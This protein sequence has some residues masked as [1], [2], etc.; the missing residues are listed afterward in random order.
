MRPVDWDLAIHGDD[1]GLH[2]DGIL[3]D[4]LVVLVV[5]NDEQD[6]VER[7][8]GAR[9]AAGGVR[10]GLATLETDL[11]GGPGEQGGAL[12]AAGVVPEHK[13]VAE[14]AAGVVFKLE[15][16]E[17]EVVLA[18]R[19]IFDNGLGAHDGHDVDVGEFDPVNEQGEFAG[20]IDGPVANERRAGRELDAEVNGRGR[21]S[22]RRSERARPC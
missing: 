7:A 19:A 6:G 13:A 14:R 16:F 3:G 21:R 15:V 2:Q 1:F 10:A 4:G 18:G 8:Q 20:S 11:E 5:G 9:F 17:A 22:E 12:A